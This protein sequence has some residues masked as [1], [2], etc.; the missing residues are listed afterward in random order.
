MGMGMVTRVSS[1]LNS[2]RVTL[3]ILSLCP[4]GRP[5]PGHHMPFPVPGS[6]CL[7]PLQLGRFGA[8]R[9]CTLWVCTFLLPGQNPFW[10]G[11]IPFFWDGN[12][13]HLFFFPF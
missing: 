3:V 9:V 2:H 13:S 7:L 8:G 1:P 6:P 10:G 12:S 11:N 5:R 4:Q